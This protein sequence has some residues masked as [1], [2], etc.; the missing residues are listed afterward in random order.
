MKEPSPSRRIVEALGEISC[1]WNGIGSIWLFLFL[2]IM[3][4]SKEDTAKCRCE[5]AT[6]VLSALPNECFPRQH[7]LFFN[8]LVYI[9]DVYY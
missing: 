5:R 2:Q 4:H 9:D 6:Q 7:M 3:V 1:T 8:L